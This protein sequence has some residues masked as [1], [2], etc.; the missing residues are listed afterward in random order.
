M[1]ERD[2][3]QEPLLTSA[4][5]GAT[6]SSLLDQRPKPEEPETAELL[7]TKRVGKRRSSARSAR[8]RRKSSMRSR[9][10][11]SIN[12]NQLNNAD[13]YDEEED[14][15][16][17][18]DDDYDDDDD[19]EEQQDYSGTTK[20]A[21]SEAD[22]K[23]TRQGPSS[24]SLSTSGEAKGYILSQQQSNVDTTAVIISIDRLEQELASL[25]ALCRSQVQPQPERFPYHSSDDEHPYSARPKRRKHRWLGP[26]VTHRLLLMTIIWQVLNIGILTLLDRRIP[27]QRI[28]DHFLRDPAVLAGVI[29]MVVFQT[30]HLILIVMASIKLAKQILHKTASNSFLIQSYLSTILLYAGVYTLLFRIDK[31]TFQGVESSLESVSAKGFIFLC[32]MKFLY[33]SVT[34]MTSTGFGD[35]TPRSWYMDAIVSSQMLISIVYTTSIFAKGLTVIAGSKAH[36][37]LVKLAQAE[38]KPASPQSPPPA[39]H[40]INMSQAQSQSHV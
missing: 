33:F 10:Q 16:D 39:A 6:V 3:D 31:N 15:D 23:Q 28:Q 40:S 35:I 4:D 1:G 29:I 5:M 20:L 36:N 30:I 17:F 11:L 37:A 9:Q 38:D 27:E 18:E 8:A 7:V 2:N 22:T 12:A 34:T 19:D 21:E 32:F 24:L 25:R 13:V 26:R 14:D